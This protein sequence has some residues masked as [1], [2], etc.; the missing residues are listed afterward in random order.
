M[1]DAILIY[2]ISNLLQTSNMAFHDIISEM[3]NRFDRCKFYYYRNKI[4]RLYETKIKGVPAPSQSNIEYSDK[5]SKYVLS[6]RIYELSKA[7]NELDLECCRLRSENEILQTEILKLQSKK[8]IEYF[9]EK[10]GKIIRKKA[11]KTY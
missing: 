2:L 3:D 10:I 4:I 6:E 7:N 9:I 11:I 5:Q 8:T 1:I